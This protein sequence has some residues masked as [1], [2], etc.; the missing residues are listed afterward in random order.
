M[1]FISIPNERGGI[2]RNDPREYNDECDEDEKKL[3]AFTLFFEFQ[4][5]NNW[6]IWCNI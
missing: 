6:L 1:R 5:N 3:D 4:K 2:K